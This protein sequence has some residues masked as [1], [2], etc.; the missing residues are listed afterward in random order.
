MNKKIKISLLFDLEIKISQQILKR[1]DY[2]RFSSFFF[3]L[4]KSNKILR[5][6]TNTNLVYEEQ[7]KINKKKSPI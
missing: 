2:L 3:V 4:L 1:N 6:S 5:H 7:R